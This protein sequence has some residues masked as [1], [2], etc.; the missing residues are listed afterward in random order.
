M[1]ILKSNIK[2]LSEQLKN[3]KIR[4]SEIV[5]EYKKASLLAQKELNIYITP[6]FDKANEQAK[7]A[8]K[9]WENGKQK[10]DF[11]GV[12]FGIKDIYLTKGEKTTNA[13]K[14]LSDFIAP[15]ESTVT[16]NLKDSGFISLGKLNMDEFAMGSANITSAFGNVINPWQANDNK[17]RVPGGSSGGSAAAV[18]A[19]AVPFALGTDTGGSIRQPASFC[20][21]VGLKPTYG[22]CSRFGIIAFAS[23]LDQAGPM[24]RSVMDNAIALNIMSGFDEHDASMP[25]MAKIDYTKHIGKSIKGLKIGL[26]EEYFSDKLNKTLQKHIDHVVNILK[27][28]GAEIVNISLPHTKYSLPVYYIIAS[29][30]ASSNFA[31]FDGIRYGKRADNAKD[32]ESVYKLSRMQGWGDEVKRRIV[33]GSYNLL[34]ENYDSYTQAA[35]VR[36]LV[37]NDFTKVFKQVDCILTPTTTTEAFCIDDSP[38]D[39]LEMYLNDIYTVTLNLAGLPGMSIPCGLGDHNLPLGIQLVGNYFKEATLYQI[40][41][42]LEKEINFN[43]LSHFVQKHNLL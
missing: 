9:R 29:A 13:S 8:D 38:N 36:R 14:F 31:R 16:K 10:S 39:P 24:T 40:A 32:L 33:L 21:L 17:L 2:E 7:E 42:S 26:P 3:N 12:P 43:Y 25:K 34:A 28:L 22:T 19:H 30:E 1:T 4:P 6:T 35:K 15:F 11:D 41:A 5:S 20:G 23:S 18:A 37:T 27:Q